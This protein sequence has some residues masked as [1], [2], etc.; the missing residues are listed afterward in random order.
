M[1]MNVTARGL[2]NMQANVLLACLAGF[3]K[4]TRIFPGHVLL[5]GMGESVNALPRESD[6]MCSLT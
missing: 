2:A 3:Q 6:V 4:P 1:E 5:T